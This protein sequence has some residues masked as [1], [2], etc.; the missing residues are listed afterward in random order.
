MKTENAQGYSSPDVTSGSQDEMDKA[1]IC[2]ELY[3]NPKEI[4]F[5]D[6][7][8]CVVGTLHS[9]RLPPSAFGIILDFVG[10]RNAL[11]L[12]VTLNPNPNQNSNPKLNPNP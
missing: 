7:C 4:E 11:M 5:D 8:E 10:P 3:L 6:A 9:P 12:K 1:A 2:V